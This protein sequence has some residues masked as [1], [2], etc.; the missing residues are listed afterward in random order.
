M[1]CKSKALISTL[2]V[3]LALTA[4]VTSSAAAANYTASKYPETMR[5][6]SPAWNVTL[7]TEAGK[8]ECA[9]L[10]EGTLSGASTDLTV[11]TNYSGCSAFGFLEASM[12][13]CKYTFTQP[14]GS[15]DFYTAKMDIVS[16]CT[17]VTSTCHVTIP[18]QGPLSSVAF[19]NET[20]AGDASVRA[21]VTGIAYTVV[22]DGFA[23]PFNGTGSKT[24][25]TYVHDSPVTFAPL[26]GGKFDVG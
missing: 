21:N 18:T 7:T 3:A 17:I 1:K 19:T 23:C 8:V 10:L 2:L 25:A 13:G 6:S 12:S 11:N 5:A 9:E 16:A 4:V 26:F 15:A 20:A 22:K 24:G 14:S